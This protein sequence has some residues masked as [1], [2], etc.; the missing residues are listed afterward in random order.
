MLEHDRVDSTTS[1]A[2]AEQS[3]ISQRLALAV[4]ALAAPI[5]ASACGGD[6]GASTGSG[7]TE[8]ST[9]RSASAS[10]PVPQ[11]VG[12]IERLH[13]ELDALLPEGTVLEVVASGFDWSEGPV[14]VG[15]RL[16]GRAGRL[17]D[18]GATGAGG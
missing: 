1:A 2:A 12:S 3:G 9:E 17:G 13:P 14:W 5:V 8:P 7:D 6:N 11:T 18:S 15:G 4:L 10:D 16:S